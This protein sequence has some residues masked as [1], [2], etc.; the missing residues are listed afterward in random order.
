MEFWWTDLPKT[1]TLKVKR[2]KLREA[3]LAG[4]GGRPSAPSPTAALPDG[5][6][7]IGA[8]STS[9]EQWVLATLSRLTHIRS[10]NLGATHRLAEIGLDS[11]SKVALIGELEARFD[12]RV[13]EASV[14]S[15]S[16]VQDLFDLVRAE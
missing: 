10:D 6:T 16:R 3:L 12:R 11:L 5:A 14:A 2:G 7:G 4:Q 15:L 9:E 8:G 1:A 13:E